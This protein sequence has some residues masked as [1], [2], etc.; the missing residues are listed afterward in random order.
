[1]K[2]LI[3]VIL[4]IVFTA[5][6]CCAAPADEYPE[7]EGG[8]KFNTNWAI[9]GVTVRIDYEEEGYR[10]CIKST[11]PFE[12][13]GVEWEYSCVYNEEQD[14][15]L[16][17]S[18]FKYSFTQDPEASGLQYG[19]YE[20]EGLDDEGKTTVF[21]VRENGSLAWND[22]HGTDGADLEF[23]DIGDF[24]G[25]WCSEDGNTWAEI[26]WDDSE[27]GDRY[28]YHVF[29]HDGGEESFAEYNTHGLYDPKTCKLETAGSVIIYTQNA[30]GELDAR[31]IPADPEDP[32]ELI[33]SDLDFD[34]LGENSRG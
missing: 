25:A 10:I 13:N 29:L 33:F 14:A 21:T 23:T 26:E 17:V 18:S 12:H 28:G 8:K 9:F 19:P 24:E 20:Y 7:P 5:L 3:S 1:M 32:T 2:K 15:L 16:S 31:E 11:D 27:E 22:G 6:L 4:A 30:E 34:F